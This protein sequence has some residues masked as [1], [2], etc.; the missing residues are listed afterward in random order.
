MISVPPRLRQAGRELVE[1]DRAVYAAVHA[2]PTPQIDHALARVSRAADRSVLWMGVAAAMAASGGRR[3]RAAVLGMMAIG[4]TSATV[5]LLVKQGPKRR[6]PSL[7]GSVRTHGVRMPG[8]HSWP[9]GHTASA[10]AFSTAAGATAPEL[11]TALRLAA[12]VVAYSR[13]HTGVHYPG[14]VMAG[15]LIGAS[16]GSASYHLSRAVR[17]RATSHDVDPGAG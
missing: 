4:A 8:S 16:M 10:F 3:R 11:E 6:R 7:E 14:D 12:T 17:R 9:S 15:A 5:N 1:L 13:V 2:T